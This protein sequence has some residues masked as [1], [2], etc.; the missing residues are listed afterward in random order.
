[1]FYLSH[2]SKVFTCK[3]IFTICKTGQAFRAFQSVPDALECSGMP[4]TPPQSYR[5]AGFDKSS[6]SER[7]A[8]CWL[9][10]LG[11]RYGRHQNGMYLDGHE[12]EDV[13]EYWHVFV[14]RFGQYKRHFHLWDDNRNK[15][16]RPNGFPVPEAHGRFRLILVTHNESTFFQ[17]NQR[18]I[19][20]GHGSKTNTP[21]P[22]G[23]GQSLMI[24]DF[25]TSEWGR[26]HDEHDGRCVHISSFR[27]CFSLCNSE[28]WVIFKPGKN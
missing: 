28:A 13:V 18:C 8:H 17:N 15:L 27:I 26:L 11:W 14:A 6:I 20:W 3:S 24:S 16:P 5:W 4:G 7:T 1:M 22:K 10:K 9:S 23:E 2:V 12:R 19:Y 25:L 21:K